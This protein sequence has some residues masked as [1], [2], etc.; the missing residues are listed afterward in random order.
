MKILL[1]NGSPNERG[2]VSFALRKM[3]E[4]LENS[5]VKTTVL[6]ID[7]GDGGCYGCGRCRELGY[8][9]HG[10]LI[11]TASELFRS[12]DALIIGTPVYYSSPSGSLLSFLDRLFQGSKFDK[13]MKVGACFATARRIGG[14]G[15][16][17]AISKYFRHSSMI[18]AHCSSPPV[19]YSKSPEHTELDREGVF[20]IE[21][22]VKNLL[23]I[24]K[25][26]ALGKSAI[27][28]PQAESRPLTDVSTL[29]CR[30]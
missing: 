4:I 26:V 10:S 22:L 27:G 18:E 14:T 5:G 8:C 15:A 21:E 13:S 25:A 1:I 11:K 17:D 23:F 16:L 29:A 6:H 20:L 7:T 24:T 12:A 28:L 19:I 30:Y 3:A 2:S 9:P